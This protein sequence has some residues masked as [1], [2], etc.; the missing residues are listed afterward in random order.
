[1]MITF[2]KK[3]KELLFSLAVIILIT[4]VN[5]YSYINETMLKP[6]YVLDGINS[7]SFWYFVR[8][9]GISQILIF[10]SPFLILYLLSNFHSKMNSGIYQD[11]ILRSN[12]RV[13]I[14]K[15]LIKLYIKC[16]LIF[17]LTS[18]LIFLV[19]LILFPHQINVIDSNI[20]FLYLPVGLYENP[21]LYVILSFLL[22]FLY[23]ILISNIGLIILTYTNKF[24]FILLSS[25]IA[26]NGINFL[27][28]NVGLIIANILKNNILY[29]IAFHINIYDG[30][31]PQST[32]FMAYVVTLIYV[33]ISSILLI[34]LYKKRE[35]VYKIY[36]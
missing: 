11:I 12:Y 17:P 28:G 26:I 30:Y 13:F 1:M 29:N 34:I 19:G 21:Y 18:L 3:N 25:F 14:R 4:A 9:S 33:V 27:I 32:I 5:V 36:G 6:F 24:H 2:I 10:V 35:R 15:E 23:G 22:N 31:S 8:N 20:S 16:G 7:F